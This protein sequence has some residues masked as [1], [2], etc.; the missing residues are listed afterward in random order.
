MEAAT[1][2]ASQG[3]E[4]KVKIDKFA[5]GPITCLKIA[6]TVD[7]QFDGKK[8]AS[9][10]KG[11]ILV[12]DLAE[13]QKISSF[14]IRE[15]VDFI[16]K[17]GQ[18]VDQLFLIECAPKVVD[19]LNMVANFAGKGR[20][21]SFYA[22]YRCDYC[23]T[24]RRALF[25]VDRDY[26]AVKSMKPPE[27][28]CPSCGNPEYFDEDPTTF[29]SY[30]AAQARF[31]LDPQ[32][33]SFLASKLNYAVSDAARRLRVEKTI[34][35]RSTYL[36]IGGDLDG[37]FPREKLAEGLEGTIILDVSGMGKVDPAGA[38]EWRGFLAMI[39]PTCEQIFLLGC[40]PVFLERLTKPEDL[41]AK[42]QVLSFG[43]PYSC[44]KCA[45]TSSQV[46][47][48]EQ[49]FDVLKFATPPEMKCTDCS[50]PTTCAAPES[51]LSHLPLLPKPT[52]DAALRKFIKE[53]QERKPEKPQL[54]TTVAEAAAAGARSNMLTVAVSLLGAAVIAI[55]AV[56][57]MNYMKQKEAEQ[58]IKARDAVGP[59]KSKSGERPPWIA[60]DTR[61]SSYCAD[62]EGGL[63][64]VGISG[65]ADTQEDAQKEAAQAALE[66]LTNQVGLKIDDPLFGH[67]RTLY[68]TA[69]Q[70]AFSQFEDA[71]SDPDGAKY[72]R[73]RRVVRD[74]RLHVSNALRASGSAAV[75]VQPA[76]EYWEEYDSVV[77][78]GSK[79][80]VFTQ[81][82]LTPDALKTLIARYSTPAEALG[83][84]VQTLFPGIAWR[85]PDVSEGVIL[86]SLGSGPLNGIGLVPQYVILSAQD[87][88]VK[89]AADF[90]T[91]TSE[92]HERLK[93]EGG[94]LKLVV[95]A[96]DG[97]PEDFRLRVART[98]PDPSTS[99]PS[100][101]GSDG[102][103]PG[104]SGINIWDRTGGGNSRDN[105]NE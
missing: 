19:Q 2:Q 47:D 6:G 79:F 75:P 96:G 53:V 100:R 58:R 60:S 38:A 4:P 42:A 1:Q 17:V 24:D 12:L 20:V 46:V 8:I 76:A 7:E 36:K 99:G 71:R 16:G 22:P 81:F 65:L 28:P 68:G 104:G 49:H 93:K 52:L 67:V 29:F 56:V 97:P 51:L 55:G 44:A 11:G 89:D 78:G 3:S 27:N 63:S 101:S 74:G 72:D 25:Q 41:G 13:I 33:A 35:G 70:V 73:A 86:V 39:T 15:W 43:M 50:G 37:S 61:F 21:F 10:L 45:T 14:G 9:T 102:T 32:V 18:S 94:N 62:E 77:G 57:A 54:A 105:P 5:D 64:C 90:A 87:R 80:L 95:K 98:T 48:V 40:P 84:K 31:E 26:E 103:R 69:R 91:K 34:E 30:I 59:L 88:Q 85:Y 66:E 82:K 92:E 23:D 83:A